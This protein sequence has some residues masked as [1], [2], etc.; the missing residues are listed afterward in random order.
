MNKTL[1][2][3]LV[4]ALGVIGGGSYLM[5]KS[6]KNF[7]EYVPEPVSALIG[8]YLPEN[9][10]AKQQSQ[11]EEKIE[12]MVE[13]APQNSNIISERVEEVE[14]PVEIENQ[15]E[16]EQTTLQKAEDLQEIE[17]NT[18]QQNE[19][20][21]SDQSNENVVDIAMQEIQNDLNGISSVNNT[22]SNDPKVMVIEKKIVAVSSEIS[23]LDMENRELKEKFQNILRKNRELAKQLQTIDKQLTR[24]N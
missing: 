2:I 3:S 10:K 14:I 15:V 21:A 8:D 1:T 20:D 12:E 22:A 9:F 7:S 6:D 17:A 11:I 18:P 24:S 16:M 19:K 4:A 5:M 23:K 13:A